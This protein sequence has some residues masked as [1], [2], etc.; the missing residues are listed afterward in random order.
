MTARFLTPQQAGARIQLDRAAI[1]DLIHQGEL[2]A[3]NVGGQ[4]N[5]ARYRIDER[6]LDRWL[7]SRRVSA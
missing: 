4:R 7:Q 5:G 3:V 1:I 2:N 6:D